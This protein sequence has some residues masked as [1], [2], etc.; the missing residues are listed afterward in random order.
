MRSLLDFLI[1][2]E[3]QGTAEYAILMAAIAVVVIIA[4][5]A[6][7]AGIGAKLNESGNK[8]GSVL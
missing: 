1:G 4:I 7:G 6:L 3:G 8:I 5:Y 2:D